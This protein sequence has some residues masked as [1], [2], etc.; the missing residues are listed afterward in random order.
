MLFFPAY[1]VKDSKCCREG[2]RRKKQ[3]ETNSDAGGE[4]V[5]KRLKEKMKRTE[6]GGG[7]CGRKRDD[8][9]GL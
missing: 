9:Y 8:L 1:L 7:E 6:T 2:V 5:G 3:T 4:R